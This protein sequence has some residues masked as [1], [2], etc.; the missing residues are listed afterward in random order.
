LVLVESGRWWIS[1]ERRGI[2]VWVIKQV[3]NKY[4]LSISYIPSLGVK[5]LFLPTWSL[6]FIVGG[7]IIT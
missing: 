4:L 5:L 7:I 1:K 2:N 3:M 6:H